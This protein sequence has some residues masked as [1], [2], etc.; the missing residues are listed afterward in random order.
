M[1]REKTLSPG[2]GPASEGEGAGKIARCR[3]WLSSELSRYVNGKVREE[4]CS[5]IDPDHDRCT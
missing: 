4:I 1:Q 3:A 2:P 5:K